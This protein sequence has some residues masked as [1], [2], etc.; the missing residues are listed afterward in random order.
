MKMNDIMNELKR[1]SLS[2]G[3]Y[4]E[5]YHGIRSMEVTDP[6]SYDFLVEE[7]E[8]MNF[9]DTVSLILYFEA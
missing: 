8:G 3:F 5:I 1:L 2:Q 7:L 6:E 9:T 4:D